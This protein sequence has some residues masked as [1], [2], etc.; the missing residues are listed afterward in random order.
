MPRILVIANPVSG[1]GR[2]AKVTEKA[3]IRLRALGDEVET[4]FTSKR[5]DAKEFAKRAKEFDR[6]VGV[7]GDGTMN[8][9]LNGL[10]E[11]PPPLGQVPVG[12]ANVLAKTFGIPKSPRPSAGVIHAGRTTEVDVGLANGR[13]FLLMASAGFDAQVVYDFHKQRIGA[14]KMREYFTHSIKAIFNYQPPVLRVTVDGEA[15]PQASFVLASNLPCYGGPLA[16]T[17]NA[18]VDDGALDVLVF[19]AG[20]KLGVV[21]LF[22]EAFAGDPCAM[23]DANFRLAKSVKIEA[24]APLPWQVDGDPG[25]K[26]PL[27]IGLAP[28]RVRLLVPDSY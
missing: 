22:A 10:P 20:G 16:F 3:A 12:T 1:R 23:P 25:E 24:D 7:G 19:H 14:I 27:E 4:L 6:V 21:R 26:L 11:D 15:L 9:I 8:E 17:R 13:K 28:K 2:G 5:G 18:K